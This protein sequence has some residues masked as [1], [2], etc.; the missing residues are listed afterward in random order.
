MLQLGGQSIAVVNQVSFSLLALVLLSGGSVLARLFLAVVIRHRRIVEPA[1]NFWMATVVFSG[2]P[3]I[4]TV[5]LEPSDEG[6]HVNV[7]HVR[8]A[9]AVTG[10]FAVLDPAGRGKI[11][12]FSGIVAVIESRVIAKWEGDHKLS[13]LLN[14][15]VERN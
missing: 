7:D 4:V 9:V 15:L 3:G 5:R 2:Q 10:P 12:G 1:R 8:S 6:L 14:N 13:R 11:C